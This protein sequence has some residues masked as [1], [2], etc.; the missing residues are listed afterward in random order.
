[1]NL[2]VDDIRKPP[3]GWTLARTI[4]QAIALLASQDIEKVSL[5]HDIAC[6]LVSGQEHSSE[7]DFSAVAHYIALMNPRPKVTFHTANPGGGARMAAIL[8][9]PYTVNCTHELDDPE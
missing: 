9:V 8:R 6:R 5:D 3:S 7:E 1:M 4:T 2:F